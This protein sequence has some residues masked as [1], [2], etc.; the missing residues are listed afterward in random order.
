MAK[1]KRKPLTAEYEL[2]CRSSADIYNET[3][4][5][6]V[7]AVALVIG[8]PYDEVYKKFTEEGR[9][10]R[11]G[12]HF[13]ITHRVLD[14]FGFKEVRIDQRGI[15]SQYPSPHCKVL[16]G[17]TSHHPAR[18][19]SVWKN[20]KKYLMRTNSHL[21]AIID[22]TTHDWSANRALRCTTLYEVVPK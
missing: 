9:K 6:S 20:G 22:G 3:N 19:N 8:K 7:K 2:L 16:K 10:P 5:C 1:I 21:L 12:T 18:F 14:H 15:L 4:D 11:H 13:S 17:L